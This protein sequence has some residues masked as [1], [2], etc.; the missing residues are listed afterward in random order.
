ML[1]ARA[2]PSPAAAAKTM[3]A[4]LLSVRW[5]ATSQ[6]ASRVAD[7]GTVIEIETRSTSKWPSSVDCKK[8][9]RAPFR[10]APS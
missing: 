10:L 5:P 6:A 3:L 7:F 8:K 2:A 1:Q 9:L 4:T